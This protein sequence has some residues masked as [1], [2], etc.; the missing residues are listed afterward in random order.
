[1][2]GYRRRNILTYQLLRLTAYSSFFSMRENKCGL[3]PHDWLPLYF[4]D[5]DD[6]D[7]PPISEEDVAELQAEMASF[8][9]HLHHAGEATATPASAEP[10]KPT[11]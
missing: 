5:D 7:T 4:D 10:R 8:N 6:Q 9:S 11:P 2:Q 1:M 3:H